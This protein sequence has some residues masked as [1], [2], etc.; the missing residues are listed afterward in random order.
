MAIVKDKRYC[1]LKLTKFQPN[2]P[3]KEEHN[4]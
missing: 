2:F 1:T 3:E 4:A